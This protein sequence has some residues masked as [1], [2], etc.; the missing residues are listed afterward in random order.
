MK[1]GKLIKSVAAFVGVA[2]LG[3]AFNI[4]RPAYASGEN[5]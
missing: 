3:L 4:A 1:Y 2:S 5:I